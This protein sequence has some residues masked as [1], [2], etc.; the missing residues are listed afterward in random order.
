MKILITGGNGY[1]A[2]SLY[3]KFKDKYKVKVITRQTFDLTNGDLMREW[4]RGQYFDVVIHTA[5][6]GGS[7]LYID[8]DTIIKDNLAMHNNLLANKIQYDKFI[9][10]GSG[11][12]LFMPD[13][14][15][16]ISKKIIT[17]SILNSENCYNLRIFGV[18]DENEL[19]TRFIKLNILRYLKKEPMVIHTNKI[20]D[21]FYMQ[22]LVNLVDHYIIN[23]DL[24][25]EINCCYDQKYTLMN[26]ANII[27]S[28]DDHKVKIQIENKSKLEFYCTYNNQFPIDVIGLE[29]AI[30][31]TY[32]AIS[33]E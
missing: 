6:K 22:D 32:K 24:Q 14:P 4:F 20:M 31:M 1:I 23:S 19:T 11:A 9:S 21:F 15:Y 27:N 8:D 10:F 26:I 25:K 13:T 28:L 18:F 33:H 17:T 16:G 12:E 29:K 5:I 3:S 2:K 30:D 7:R